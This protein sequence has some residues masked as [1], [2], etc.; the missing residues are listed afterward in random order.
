[1]RGEALMVL[2]V[3]VSEIMLQQTQVTTVIGY[4]ERWMKKFPT[5]QAL[6]MLTGRTAKTVAEFKA[7]LANRIQSMAKTQDLL[8]NGRADRVGVREV[9]EA[10]LGPYLGSTNQ[11]EFSCESMTIA[12]RSA[13]SLGLLVH[14]LLTNAAKYGA[15][16]T[17][18]GHLTVRCVRTAG[19]ALLDWRETTENAVVPPGESGFGTLLIERLARSLGGRAELEMSATGLR[20][21][22]TYTPD[23]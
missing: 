5:V 20:A 10:E 9:L 8:L 23:V 4:W 22:I 13:V 18:G 2:Q 16:S 15:L 6:A 19:G 3:W 12:A 11:V 1:M 17:P 21:K 14:E 7:T